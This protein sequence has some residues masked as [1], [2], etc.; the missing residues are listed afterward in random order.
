MQNAAIESTKNRSFN[1]AAKYTFKS[2]R[3][4]PGTLTGPDF[5]IIRIG[6]IEYNGTLVLKEWDVDVMQSGISDVLVQIADQ[7]RTTVAATAS[8]MLLFSVY[9]QLMRFSCH[10]NCWD[11]RILYFTTDATWGD[12]SHEQRD[13]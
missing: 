10:K 8:H 2:P 13:C 9:V 6:G 4:L 7:G 5:P 3:R 12:R 11:N 1:E